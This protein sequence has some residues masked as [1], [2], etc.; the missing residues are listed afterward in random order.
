MIRFSSANNHL[1]SDAQL[2]PV[3]G[4]AVKIFEIEGLKLVRRG[5]SAAAAR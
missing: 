3:L 1:G 4:F 2:G 5:S